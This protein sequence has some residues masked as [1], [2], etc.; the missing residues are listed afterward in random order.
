MKIG[1]II[2]LDIIDMNERGVGI[3][4]VDGA[5][6]FVNNAVVGDT[7]NVRITASEKNYFLGEW[8]ELIVASDAR[9]EPVCTAHDCGGCTLSHISYELENKI[10]K[11][12]V[13]NAFRRAGLDYSLVED[14]VFC[15]NRIGY[16]NKIT[17]HYSKDKKCFGLYKDG[18]NDVIPFCVCLICPD[19]I[20]EIVKFTNNNIDLLYNADPT[21]LCVRTSASGDLSVSLY[22]EKKSDISKYV[23]AL[24]NVFPSISG[25]N[26]IVNGKGGGFLGDRILD[27][28]MRFSSE[29]F[30][31]VNTPAFEKLL[32]IVHGFASEAEFKCGADLYC[33][34]GIIGLTLAKKFPERTFYGIEINADAIK[35]A[36]YNAEAN[37]IGNIKFFC[38]DSATFKKKIGGGR[39]PEFIVVDPPRAGLSKEMRA[40]LVELSPRKIIYVSCNP[41]TLARDLSALKQSGYE[42]KHAV[43]V[44]MFPMTSHCECVV[45]LEKAK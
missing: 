15:E 40:G 43:P 4:K 34:S 9:T 8:I 44:N 2:K 36:K 11:N 35:D 26:H 3:G 12:T 10:K 20:S 33:G 18:T 37:G 7:A 19:I 31:Q 24:A 27:V 22:S 42:I 41:Q 23:F 32:S 6:V 28:D 39:L 45:N 1:D 14:T 29:A 30:R 13:S 21:S 17:V 5:V 38:G 25:V 16:R